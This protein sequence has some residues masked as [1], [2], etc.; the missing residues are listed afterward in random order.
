MRANPHLAVTLDKTDTTLNQGFHQ[1]S[2]LPSRRPLGIYRVDGQRT[3]R[4][5]ALFL[6]S[7]FIFCNHN[8]SYLICLATLTIAQTREQDDSC[9]HRDMDFRAWNFWI[10]SLCW[11]YSTALDLIGMC[12]LYEL[13]CMWTNQT[14]LSKSRIHV[15]HH[16]RFI[17]YRTVFF[18]FMREVLPFHSF[19]HSNTA[20]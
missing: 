4:F 7:L 12:F 20:R 18:C 13:R 9:R 1:D 19:N 8:F 16:S 14:T 17:L 5:R 15:W 3:P 2:C 10:W 6:F 11:Y